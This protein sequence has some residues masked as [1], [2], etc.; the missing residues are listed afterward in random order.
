MFMV[1]V[2]D[3]AVPD[4]DVSRPAPRRPVVERI[5]C[6]SAQH[7]LIV[8]G[9]WL[10]GVG[11]AVFVGQVAGGPSKPQYD[12]GQTGRTEHTLNQLGVVTPPA[13]SVLIQERLP[14]ATFNSDLS[15]QQATQAVVTALRHLPGAAED[16][17]TPFGPAGRALISADGRSALVTFRVA[18]PH[19]LADTTVSKDLAAVNRVQAR[20][21]SLLVAEAG[22]ASTDAVGNNLM[23]SDFHK[24]EFTSVPITLVLLLVVFGALIAAG[25]PVLLAG[26]SVIATISVL[27]AVGR[28]LPLGQST[29]ELVLILGMAV[30]VDYSLFY[31]RR[32]REERAAGKSFPAA[33]QIAAATSGRAIVVSGLTV[34]ISL[35]GLFLTGIDLFTGMAYGTIPVVGIAVAASL[36]LLPAL[37][38]LL[39]RWADRCRLPVLGRRQTAARPSQLWGKIVRQVVRH[40]LRWG[41]AAVLTLLAIASPVVGMRIGSPPID[42]PNSL[43]SVQTLNRISAAFP[44]RPAPAQVVITSQNLTSRAMRSAVTALEGRASNTGQLQPPITVASVAGGR[45]LIAE[46]PLAGDGSDAASVA[47]LQTLRNKVLPA[48]VGRV[49][50]VS[51]SVGGATAADADWSSVLDARTPIVLAVAAM[52]AFIVLLMAFRSLTL[53]LVSIGL[54]LLSVGAACG[55]MVWVFQD[56]NLQGLLG[57]TSYGAV[58]QWVPLFTFVLLFGL[59]MDYHVF[60]LS[61]IRERRA[62]GATTPEAIIGGIAGS[63]GVVTSAAVIM[64][65]VFSIFATLSFIDVKMLGVGLAFAVLIDATLVRGIL[66]PAAMTALGE[67]C[68]YLPRGLAWLPTLM[69]EGGAGQCSFPT[70]STWWPRP[71]RRTLAPRPATVTATVT[72]AVPVPVPVTAGVKAV[73]APEGAD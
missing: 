10:L 21:P 72:A 57:F 71:V 2:R 32:E 39:G 40:P 34:M 16:I 24:A 35:G 68:W 29:S 5:A 25:I 54:N 26:A 73:T 15:M 22:S 42:L 8:L 37:L 14:G 7:R 13:E 43:P 66:V 31:L 1:D 44:V 50:G 49:P 18:G 52:L 59:S 27:A 46:V 61:R 47:A 56:G 65:A 20:F 6:W 3:K 33:L 53:P 63:A 38:S 41:A 70:T 19:D 60:I 23:N 36:T 67:R 62:G 9:A 48:T 51:Y 69:A 28:W 45:A 4:A 30:G 58:S 12:P 55:L 11:L 64:V 17:T